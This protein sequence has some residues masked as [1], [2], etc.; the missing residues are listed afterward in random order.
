MGREAQVMGVMLY[1]ATPKERAAM[2]AGVQAKLHSGALT[3]DV[4]R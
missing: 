4:R 1:A 3:P 2:F